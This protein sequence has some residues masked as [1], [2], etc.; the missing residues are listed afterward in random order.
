MSVALALE[1]YHVTL[2]EPSG[3]TIAGVQGARNLS[4]VA[5][6][7]LDST[8]MARVDIR[9]ATIEQFHPTG[10]YDIVYCRQVVHHF[11]DP[12]M[13]LKKVRSL[14]SEKGVAM[15]VREHVIFDDEDKER[16]L[17]GHALQ[18]YTGGEN[19]Y[20]AE[21][22]CAFIEAAGMRLAKQYAF[23]ESPINFYPH[24]QEAALLLDES[25]ISGR[26]YSFIAVNKESA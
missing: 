5:N 8:V 6:E 22:Y 7:L 16:F 26:P 13:A 23:K 9:Q 14:L 25:S 15:F 21:E 18:K 10:S 12:V 19:A 1:G 4:Q 11:H 24:S 20:T 17:E 3:D 2:A